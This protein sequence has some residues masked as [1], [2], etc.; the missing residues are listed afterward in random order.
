[1][2]N[3]GKALKIQAHEHTKHAY[4]VSHLLLGIGQGILDSIICLR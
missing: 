4:K 2:L 1:M 3:F